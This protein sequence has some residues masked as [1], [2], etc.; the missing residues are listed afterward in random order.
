MQSLLT[1]KNIEIEMEIHPSQLDRIPQYV[2]EN[3]QHLEG[4]IFSQEHGYIRKILPGTKMEFVSLS[5]N[6]IFGGIIYKIHF[7]ALCTNPQ[8]D[9]ILECEIFQ[10]E[11]I[12]FSFSEPMHILLTHDETQDISNIK[13]GD[14]VLAKVEMFECEKTTNI[15]K[16]VARLINIK[17]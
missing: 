9:D 13:K 6:K 4:K 12:M 16:V 5:L 15:I 3:L 17:Y 10:N 8:K 2:K 14:T 11:N 7:H 1:I